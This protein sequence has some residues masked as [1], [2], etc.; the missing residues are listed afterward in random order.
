MI[1]LSAS[2][3]KE[4]RYSPRVDGWVLIDDL[5]KALQDLKEGKDVS[6]EKGSL[7]D[8]IDR[9]GSSSGLIKK[10]LVEGEKQHLIESDLNKSIAIARALAYRGKGFSEAIVFFDTILSLTGGI[11]VTRYDQFRSMLCLEGVSF[12]TRRHVDALTEDCFGVLDKYREVVIEGLEGNES[13]RWCPIIGEFI[14]AALSRQ[15]QEIADGILKTF[16]DSALAGESTKI[17]SGPEKIAKM[18]YYF[19]EGSELL[20][21]KGKM[22]MGDIINR[23]GF[24][25]T[26]RMKIEEAWEQSASRSFSGE[27][28]VTL[29]DA[30]SRN[31]KTHDLVG[32]TKTRDCKIFI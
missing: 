16:I 17:S 13:S 9:V 18:V 12:L 27:R 8:I 19:L 6:S 3:E 10:E 26:E 30:I 21:R 5:C 24:D 28:S 4:L 32:A 2:S 20:K 15:Q 1:D 29:G 31:L 23:Y 22:I 14:E 11:P 7:R 25:G